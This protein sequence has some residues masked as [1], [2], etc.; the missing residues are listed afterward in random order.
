MG[1]VLLLGASTQ[2]QQSCKTHVQVLVTHTCDWHTPLSR[3][4][5]AGR[6]KQER[7]PTEAYWVILAHSLGALPTRLAVLLIPQM[8]DPYKLYLVVKVTYQR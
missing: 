4:V 3:C 8:A 6:S 7:L 5:L 2:T 1:A